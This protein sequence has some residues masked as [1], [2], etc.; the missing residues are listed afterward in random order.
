[1]ILS[2]RTKLGFFSYHRSAHIVDHFARHDTYIFHTL[3][4]S[5]VDGK[6]FDIR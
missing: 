2:L 6:T 5:R 3:R 4:K 1:M